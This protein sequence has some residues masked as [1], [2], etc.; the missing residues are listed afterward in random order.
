M[1]DELPLAE[2][3]VAFIAGV[4]AWFSWKANH[5]ASKASEEAKGANKAVNCNT[6]PN[7]PRLY[8]LVSQNGKK[9]AVIE[10]RVN[11]IRDKQKL[12]EEKVEGLSEGQIKHSENLKSHHEKLVKLTNSNG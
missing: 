5:E 2:A 6:D 12:I 8:D 9:V 11:T 4:G 7:A 1:M 10:E 3:V